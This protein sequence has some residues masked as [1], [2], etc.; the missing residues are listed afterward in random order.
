MSYRRLV[1]LVLLV[2][3]LSAGCTVC[4]TV[5]ARCYPSAVTYSPR[6]S[7]EPINFIH[8]RQDPPPV[9]MLGP[10]DV[11]GIYIEGV[12]GQS[13]EPPPVHFPEKG[14]LA[15]AIGFPMP[16]RDDGTLSLPLV[17]PLQIGGLSLAQA[18]RMIRQA[19]TVDHKILQPGR[20]R[21]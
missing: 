18:E 2:A 17:P 12:L 16:V 21:I 14:N 4:G 19:Y 20:D 11:L 3:P 13:D 6:S 15:P 5:P 10:R 8:L 7:Q 9:Y 1:V